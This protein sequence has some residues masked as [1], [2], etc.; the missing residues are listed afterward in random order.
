MVLLIA[1]ILEVDVHPKTSKRY[2]GFNNKINKLLL[3][4]DAGGL[5]YDVFFLYLANAFVSPLSTYFNPWYF[6]RLFRRW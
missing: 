5:I 3:N 4:L 1:L 2:W 6:F